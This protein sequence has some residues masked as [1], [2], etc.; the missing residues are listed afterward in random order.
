M[1]AVFHYKDARFA[2]FEALR[3]TDNYSLTGDHLTLNRARR[4]RWPASG[5]CT[6]PDRLT[7]EAR[8]MAGSERAWAKG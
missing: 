2:F 3:I 8:L 6:C 4:R 5:R 1:R 7:A